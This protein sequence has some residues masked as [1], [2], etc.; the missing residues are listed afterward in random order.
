MLITLKKGNLKTRNIKNKPN[1][2]G[3][4]KNRGE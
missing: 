4:H 2:M 3:L 1:T